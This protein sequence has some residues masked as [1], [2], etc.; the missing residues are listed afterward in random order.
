MEAFSDIRS[1]LGSVAALAQGS[2]TVARA[3]EPVGVFQ[4]YV[5]STDG[6]GSWGGVGGALCADGPTSAERSDRGTMQRAVCV[7]AQRD[8]ACFSGHSC[9]ARPWGLP[10]SGSLDSPFYVAPRWRSVVG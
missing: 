5:G 4:N 9:I 2:R 8:Q 1:T 3:D 7:H 10:S 6:G